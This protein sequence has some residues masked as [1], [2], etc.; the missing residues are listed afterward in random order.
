MEK[1]MGKTNDTSKLD[2][3]K[4]ENRPLAD[5]E[6]DAVSGGFNLLGGCLPT[7]SVSQSPHPTGYLKMSDIELKRS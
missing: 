1:F 5:S 2:H 6:L 7:P 4:L 3:A